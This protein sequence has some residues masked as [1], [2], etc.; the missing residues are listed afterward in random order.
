MWMRR[1]RF[2]GSTDFFAHLI[3]T[4]PQA[5]NFHTANWDTQLI[6]TAAEG[7]IF[8]HLIGTAAEGGIF[9]HLIGT[10][11]QKSHRPAEGGITVE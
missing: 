3:G 1:R 2:W 8:L 10:A 6:G 5:K 4:A 7:E 9:L 11:R